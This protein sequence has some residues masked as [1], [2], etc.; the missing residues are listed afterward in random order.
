MNLYRRGEL[1]FCDFFDESVPW[2]GSLPHEARSDLQSLDGNRTEVRFVGEAD[3]DDIAF[4]KE[5]SR[6]SPVAINF[7]LL[8]A[9][10]SSSLP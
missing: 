3:R 5:Y 10:A 7:G 4:S 1:R 9:A 2:A 8:T 6:D